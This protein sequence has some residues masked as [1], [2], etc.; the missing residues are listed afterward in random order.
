MLMVNYTCLTTHTAQ[1]TCFSKTLFN[2]NLTLW[3]Q[4]PALFFFSFL[5]FFFFSIFNFM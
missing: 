1:R 3:I 2:K 4:D 5:S